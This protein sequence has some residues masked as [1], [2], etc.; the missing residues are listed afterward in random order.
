MKTLLSIIFGFS[1]AV[2]INAAIIQFDLI[3]TAGNGLLAGNEP[4][5]SVGGSGGEIGAG[6]TFNDATLVLSVNVGWGSGNGFSNLTSAVS[7]QHIHGPTANNYGNG[8][9]E[10]AGVAIGLTNISSSPTNGAI[11]QNVTLTA[12]QKTNLYNGKFYINVHTATNGVGE[13]RGFLV[14]L[15]TLALSVT[16]Q[17][18][19]VLSGFANQRQVIQVSSNLVNWTALIT[20]SSGTNFF[21]FT[22]NN[23]SQFPLRHYRARVIP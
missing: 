3:G 8:Y 19:L 10:T 12:A 21:Q 2:Q 22:E 23:P 11:V 7:A 5:V 4:S 18:N 20:N 16:N 13:I 14:A 17:A 6:I 15:P 9:A 1:F